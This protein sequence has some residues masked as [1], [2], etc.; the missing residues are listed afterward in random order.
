MCGLFWGE[1]GERASGGR[2]GSL[3]QNQHLEDDE[4]G[5]WGFEGWDEVF[6]ELIDSEDLLL[7]LMIGG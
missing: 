4:G 6:L 2:E 1:G 3:E 5:R 7:N